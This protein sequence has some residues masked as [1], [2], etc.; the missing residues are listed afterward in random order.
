MWS[1]SRVLLRNN[2]Q[3]TFAGITLSLQHR[4][5][6]IQHVY[7]HPEDTY[8]PPLN[9][10]LAISFTTV[11]FGV[12]QVQQ[13]LFQI[14][15]IPVSMDDLRILRTSREAPLNHATYRASTYHVVA[16]MLIG[17]EV[18]WKRFYWTF[19]TP[20]MAVVKEMAK[21]RLRGGG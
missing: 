6:C 13:N 5:S 21:V 20:K 4:W 14:T 2:P 12:E 11:I 9:R 10:T 8:P 15:S 1:Y 18:I 7:N 16:A 17:I 19:S 3:S